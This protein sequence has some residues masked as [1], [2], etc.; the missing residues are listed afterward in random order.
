MLVTVVAIVLVQTNFGFNPGISYQNDKSLPVVQAT[1]GQVFDLRNIKA[2]PPPEQTVMESS[3]TRKS[4]PPDTSNNPSKPLPPHSHSDPMHRVETT[5][6]KHQP[7]ATPTTSVSPENRIKQQASVDKPVSSGEKP[8]SSSIEHL[9]REIGQYDG[10]ELPKQPVSNDMYPSLKQL[11]SDSLH[12]VLLPVSSDI[13][14]PQQSSKQALSDPTTPNALEIKTAPSI[15][16]STSNVGVRLQTDVSKTAKSEEVHEKEFHTVSSQVSSPENTS[17]TTGAA[18]P[19]LSNGKK[20]KGSRKS[21][22]KLQKSSQAP[23]DTNSNSAPAA[24]S[25]VSTPVVIA[26]QSNKDYLERKES[27]SSLKST[28]SESTGSS[29]DKSD[30]KEDSESVTPPMDTKGSSADKKVVTLSSETV[31]KLKPHQL[32][33][34][35]EPNT[36]QTVHISEASPSSSEVVGNEDE[37]KRDSGNLR[38]SKSKRKLRQQKR[39]EKSRKK[40]KEKLSRAARERADKNHSLMDDSSCSTEQLDDETAEEVP[41]PKPVKPALLYSPM[42]LQQ[43]QKGRQ[44]GSSKNVEPIDPRSCVLELNIG[45]ENSDSTR[46]GSTPPTLPPPLSKAV[47]L[48]VPSTAIKS[49]RGASGKPQYEDIFSDPFSRNPDRSTYA[50]KK[51]NSKKPADIAAKAASEE[52]PAGTKLAEVED[53]EGKEALDGSDESIGDEGDSNTTSPDA[54]DEIVLSTELESG[55]LKGQFSAANPTSP[56]DLAASLLSKIPM[57]RS[58]NRSVTSRAK[59]LEGLEYEDDDIEIMKQENFEMSDEVEKL[60]RPNTLSPIKDGVMSSPSPPLSGEYKLPSSLSLDAEPFYPSSNFKSKKHSRSEHKQRHDGKKGNQRSGSDRKMMADLKDAELRV[61]HGS[62][63]TSLRGRT[64]TEGNV[65]QVPM[66]PMDKTMLDRA[67]FYQMHR[68]KASTPPSF[69]Y[70]DPQAAYRY[71]LLL[72]AQD[73]LGELRRSAG[74]DPYYNSG[75]MDEAMLHERSRHDT[76]GLDPAYLMQKAARPLPP[77]RSSNSH[78]MSAALYQQQQQQQQQKFQH[79]SGY[80]QAP[81][82]FGHDV[83]ASRMQQYEDDFKRQRFLRRRKLIHDLYRQER[84]ALAAVYAREQARKSAE[85][86]SSLHNPTR[87]GGLFSQEP[88]KHALTGSHGNLWD[89]YLDPPPASHQP[90]L[91]AFDDP[92]PTG[93][94]PEPHH[95]TSSYLLGSSQVPS[96]GRNLSEASDIGGE[97]L[98]NYQPPGLQSPTSV[99]PP[100]YQRAPGAEY[101]RVEQQQQDHDSVKENALMLQRQKE[102]QGLAWP[103]EGEVS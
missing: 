2:T 81:P 38:S 27:E 64:P 23:V 92:N 26:D 5:P 35:K 24:V 89:D 69:P 22:S 97:M 46:G 86:L 75:G 49:S 10:T 16:H 87:I 82:G 103:P 102:L 1:G 42:K 94:D 91:R 39:E 90:H 99:G 18:F 54:G 74:R 65:P 63:S 37:V 101:S 98:S 80:P 9:E 100:G 31:L 72:D 53:V 6:P 73:H 43:N 40:E 33:L 62:K 13:S 50:R 95:L 59:S 11:E 55:K 32:S 66:G 44:K 77:M 61:G 83:P 45:T 15:T 19:P 3:T 14:E 60:A 28:D 70:G 96:R 17:P 84:A 51:T 25:P 29:G 57:K 36:G 12:A 68:E 93:T 34:A 20:L 58:S 78:R 4:K 47:S 76:S 41:A 52:S 48:S 79:M 71:D 67:E 21:S 30:E 8:P 85:A 88:N 56:H 7:R